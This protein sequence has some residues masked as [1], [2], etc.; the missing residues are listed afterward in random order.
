MRIVVLRDQLAVAQAQQPVGVAA[1][2]QAAVVVLEQAQ[3]RI[4][5]QAIGGGIARLH[6][7]ATPTIEA[8]AGPDP[9]RAIARLRQRAHV[10]VAQALVAVHRAEGRIAQAQQA[11]IGADPET[12][13]AIGQQG[14]D[15][16][17]RQPAQAGEF[18]DPG[19]RQPQQAIVD[20][21]DPQ[22][23]GQVLREAGNAVVRQQWRH[24]REAIALAPVDAA[25]GADEQR[26][27]CIL[28]DS[29]HRRI[30][31]SGIAPGDRH[32]AIDE[33][34]QTAGRRGP[35]AVVAVQ[36]QAIG[37]VVGQAAAGAVVDDPA[38][39]DHVDAGI[40]GGDPQPSLAV[41]QRVHDFFLGQAVLDHPGAPAIAALD[42]D[43]AARGSDHQ[44]AIFGGAHRAHAVVLQCRRVAAVEDMEFQAVVT[45]QAFPGAEPQVAVRGL[46][47]GID[48]VVR[49]AL[50][51]GPG[52]AEIRGQR[53]VLRTGDA[54]QEHAKQQP[55]SHRDAAQETAR[56]CPPHPAHG[57]PCLQS[58]RMPAS[59]PMKPR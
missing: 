48:L 8:T 42:R 33:T 34:D 35:D 37:H 20:G 44:R 11:C 43:P 56:R 13:L 55:C 45:G 25:F 57:A 24:Q 23:A 16:V 10:I 38:A 7:A 3:H 51:G 6:L 4:P 31:Q 41:E 47:D 21:A 18:L 2:Q 50:A 28:D 22:V 54:G 12:A 32:A 1:D 53:L 26:A 5:G 30:G 17:V 27:A 58:A 39:I 40:L 46:R 19:L 59:G 14:G 49:Q 9:Q 15:A 29:E 52:L 36:Q